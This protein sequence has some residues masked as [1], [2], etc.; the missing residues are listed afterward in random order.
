MKEEIDFNKGWNDAVRGMANA[1]ASGTIHEYFAKI[2]NA[3]AKIRMT[4][5]Y[6]G[7]FA[8][9][10]EYQETMAEEMAVA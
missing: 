2:N 9:I 10:Q 4:A 3:S 8:A 1:K 6:K 5:Y 7:V